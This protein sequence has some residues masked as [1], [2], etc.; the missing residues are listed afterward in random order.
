MCILTSKPSRASRHLKQNRTRRSKTVLRFTNMPAKWC[1]QNERLTQGKCKSNKSSKPHKEHPAERSAVGPRAPLTN[2]LAIG[3][4]SSQGQRQ[5]NKQRP[6]SSDKFRDLRQQVSDTFS[7]HQSHSGRPL[8]K[9]V[10]QHWH[11][12]EQVPKQLREDHR[13]SYESNDAMHRVSLQWRYACI[14]CQLGKASILLF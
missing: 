11:D 1:T 5:V 10:H 3:Q 2:F 6:R 13:R 14:C 9:L 7:K 12:G 8:A 4:G